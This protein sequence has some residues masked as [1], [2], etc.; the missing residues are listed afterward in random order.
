MLKKIFV[1]DGFFLFSVIL[2]VIGSIPFTISSLTLWPEYSYMVAF[3]I[4]NVICAIALYISYKKH[5]KNVMKGLSGFLLMGIL[6]IAISATFPLNLED[7]SY[8]ILS[9]INLSVIIAL[10]INHFVINA[11]HHSKSINVYL[12]Q[13]LIITEFLL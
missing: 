4:C 12:N 7:I 10:C 2:T 1:N 9:L 5:S 3:L 6:A 13:W 8:S 11:D